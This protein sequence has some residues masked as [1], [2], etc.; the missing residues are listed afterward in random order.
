M[1]L[2]VQIQFWPPRLRG[3]C[4]CL[5]VPRTSEYQRRKDA[6]WYCG[7][8][9]VCFLRFDAWPTRV[10]L[11]LPVWFSIEVSWQK[12]LHCGKKWQT[13]KLLISF[14]S[15]FPV[16]VHQL[17]RFSTPRRSKIRCTGKHTEGR[18]TEL[19]RWSPWRCS[20]RSQRL[21]DLRLCGQLLQCQ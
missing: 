7:G 16:F 15:L 14:D 13:K 1:A 3:E 21:E 18:T 6:H 2:E 10:P 9:T 20:S 11:Y 5:K 19:P 17:M 12:S 8:R 4:V